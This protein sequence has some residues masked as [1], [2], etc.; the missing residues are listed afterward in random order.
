MI[1]FTASRNEVVTIMEIADRAVSIAQSRQI[2]YSKQDAMMDIEA[3]HCNGTPLRLNDL[4]AA[5][6]LNFCHDV[7]GIRKHINRD[8]GKLENHFFPRFSLTTVTA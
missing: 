2:D 3:T 6:D 8:T 7:F 4:A 1:K 5:D